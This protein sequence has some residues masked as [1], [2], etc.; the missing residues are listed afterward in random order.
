[1]D[2]S[3]ETELQQLVSAVGDA[4]I[5]AATP[6]PHRPWLPPLPVLVELESLAVAADGA[7]TEDPAGRPAIGLRD[8]PSEQR[9]DLFRLDFDEDGSALVFG[10]GGSGKSA[11]L[12]TV[13][14]SLAGGASPREVEIYALDF[15]T[16]ALAPLAR[17]PHVGAV[18]AG[19]DSERVERL[20]A[21]LRALVRER[22]EL[23]A[24]AGYTSFA[25]HNRRA[26]EGERLPR[27]VVLLDDYSGF[28]AKYER[29]RMGELLEVLPRLASDGRSLGLHFVL[30]ASRRSAIPMALAGAISRRLVLRMASEDEYSGLGI[31]WRTIRD[32]V[33]PPGRVLLG[34]EGE[35]Q[36]ALLGAGDEA[37][38]LEALTAEVRSRWPGQAARPI[39]VLPES[40]ARASLPVPSAPGEIV[41]GVGGD[42]IGAVSARLSGILLVA[43]P[44]R[45]GRSTALET[46]AL[47]LAAGPRPPKLFALLPR[48][49]PLA[50]L[51]IWSAAADG[52]AECEQLVAELVARLGEEP[53]AVFVD[54]AEELQQGPVSYELEKIV[55]ATR[56]QPVTLVAA[57]ERLAAR[58]AYTGWLAEARKPGSGLLLTPDIDQD[59]EILNLPRLPR[60]ISWIPVP[61]RG[62]LVQEGN[63]I[64]LQ[65]ASG[66]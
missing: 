49:S 61:G 66:S 58:R 7:G 54:D 14:L 59:G 43:G 42:A 31:N 57:V 1:M 27:V 52:V 34:D 11:L 30:T 50:A 20:F 64:L 47:S 46:A 25:D 33:V 8:V 51:P 62:F 5:A 18:V 13:A 6:P 65:V 56:T 24:A 12:R 44:Y 39:A 4:A 21:R 32:V 3:E 36:I 28:A 17:L 45:S 15:A 37:G 63:A 35:A 23:F 29:V 19:D 9:Q 38:A 53:I 2:E 22:K 26:P 16:R 40:V 48:R 41:L 10:G 55:A 60:E